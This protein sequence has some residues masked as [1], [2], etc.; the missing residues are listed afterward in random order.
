MPAGAS[1]ALLALFLNGWKGEVALGEILL[2][3]NPG[4][5]SSLRKIKQ[6]PSK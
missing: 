2:V 5:P 6:G 3:T 1:Q 4:C